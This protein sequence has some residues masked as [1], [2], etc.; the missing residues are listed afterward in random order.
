LFLEEPLVGLSQLTL[1]DLHVALVDNVDQELAQALVQLFSIG[2]RESRLLYHLALLLVGS[3]ID[4]H[5]FTVEV[6]G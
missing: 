4:P 5:L 1:F 6:E 3:T 2:L